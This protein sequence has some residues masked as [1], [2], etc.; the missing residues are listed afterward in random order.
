MMKLMKVLSQQNIK[1]P[2]KFY[3]IAVH[4]KLYFEDKYKV[5]G[6]QHK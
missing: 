2:E 3:D 4:N 6:S 1:I 5:T